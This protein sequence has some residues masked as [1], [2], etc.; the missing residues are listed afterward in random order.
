MVTTLIYGALEVVALN[1]VGE[2]LIIHLL[3][4]GHHEFK[5]LITFNVR[6][7]NHLASVPS[8]H[9]YIISIPSLDVLCIQETKL[10]GAN[11]ASLELDFG[12]KFNVGAL[13]QAK[14]MLTTW[15]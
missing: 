11:V 5:N 12:P 13:R 3:K 14:V 4:R 1:L 8:L 7:L 6:G 10:W 15:T 2:T 9:N